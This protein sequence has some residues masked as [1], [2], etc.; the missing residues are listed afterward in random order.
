MPAQMYQINP[1]TIMFNMKILDV[2][3]ILRDNLCIFAMYP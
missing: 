2:F 3:A 1:R